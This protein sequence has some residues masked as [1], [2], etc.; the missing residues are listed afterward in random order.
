MIALGTA[1]KS[2]ESPYHR[3]VVIDAALFGVTPHLP[4]APWLD[5]CDPGDATRG[6]SPGPLTADEP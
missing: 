2:T 1:L 5:Y 4:T 6:R 3:C